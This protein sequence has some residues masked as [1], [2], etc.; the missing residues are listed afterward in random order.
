MDNDITYDGA[1]EFA[2]KA[3]DEVTTIDW[4]GMKISV[5]KYIDIY[6][7]ISIVKN[8]SSLCF[9]EDSGEYMPELVDFATKMLVVDTYTNINKCIDVVKKYDVI[10][11]TDLFDIVSSVIDESQLACIFDGV[12][13]RVRYTADGMVSSM[14]SAIKQING[15]SEKIGAIFEN[16]STEDFSK[17]V[18]GIASG[19]IDESKIISAYI[20]E[21]RRGGDKLS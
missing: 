4:N 19:E 5:K 3:N 17:A 14:Q 1:Y 11:R 6:N 16:V 21:K 9:S 7:M 2:N 20:D 10:C 15:V 12:S 8:A 18:T 13:K